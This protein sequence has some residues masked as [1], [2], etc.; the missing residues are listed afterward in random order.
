MF[1]TSTEEESARVVTECLIS[2][3]QPSCVHRVSCRQSTI[4]QE[5]WIK[6][7]APSFPM[8]QG[9]CVVTA[10]S[11]GAGITM[12]NFSELWF[13]LF[14]LFFFSIPGAGPHSVTLLTHLLRTDYWEPLPWQPQDQMTGVSSERPSI[15]IRHSVNC[16]FFFFLPPL[17]S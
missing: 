10:F 6:P 5:C 8:L 14:L 15:C 11:Q 16:F 1:L 9:C 4:R 7:P 2:Q 12:Q 17:T 3:T 13:N